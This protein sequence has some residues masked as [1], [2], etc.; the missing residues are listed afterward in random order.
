MYKRRTLV[1]PPPEVLARFDRR[2]CGANVVTIGEFYMWPPEVW[3][4]ELGLGWND[5]LCMGCLESRL[6]R[7]VRPFR[8]LMPVSSR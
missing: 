1:N 3:K 4:G 8:D 5:N 6:G 2:D 7:H